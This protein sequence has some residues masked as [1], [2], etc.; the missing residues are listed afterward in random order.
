MN[1]IDHDSGV[2]KRKGSLNHRFMLG[3]WYNTI[4][5]LFDK[6][7]KRNH[8][9]KLLRKLTAF[10]IIAILIVPNVTIGADAKDDNIVEANTADEL[11]EEINKPENDGKTIRYTGE[12][13]RM[14]T[15]DDIINLSS[16]NSVTLDLG[17]KEIYSIYD[18]NGGK[19]VKGAVN[20]DHGTLTITNGSVTVNAAERPG[21]ENQAFAVNA[22]GEESTVIIDGAV[23]SGIDTNIGSTIKLENGA[24]LIVESGTV[25]ADNG[26][27]IGTLGTPGGKIEIKGGEF[28]LYDMNKG[29]REIIEIGEKYDVIV[30]G[31]SF[32]REP[33]HHSEGKA[34]TLALKDGYVYTE[35]NNRWVV[36]EAIV[37]KATDETITVTNAREA[38][39]YIAADTAGNTFESKTNTIDGLSPG[40]TYEIKIKK[41]DEVIAEILGTTKKVIAPEDDKTQKA[42][43]SDRGADSLTVNTI[44]TQEYSI[45]DGATWIDGTGTPHVFSGLE[46]GKEYTILTRIAETNDTMPSRAIE[47]KASTLIASEDVEMPAEP[48]VEERTDQTLTLICAEDEEMSIDSGKNWIAGPKVTFE[49]LEEGTEYTVLVRKFATGEAEASQAVPTKAATMIKVSGKVDGGEL[50]VTVVITDPETGRVLAEVTTDENGSW[51]AYLDQKNYDIKYI[52]N[53]QE[54]SATDK[55]EASEQDSPAADT[56]EEI[57]K[58]SD[59]TGIM[60]YIGMLLV[61]LGI[62]A[63]ALN[64]RKQEL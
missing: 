61:S 51:T 53:S 38:T 27:L 22:S 60:G 62:F 16:G 63:V 54:E 59:A 42:Q 25:S 46:S 35:E 4:N 19:G 48:K 45:D 18:Y 12:N 13:I 50:S 40:T 47:T 34:G 21:D 36:E 41:N 31:G 58:T 33:K 43:I 24:N 23:I 10:A 17:G 49:G 2:A 37:E 29:A 44:A 55:E 14:E 5:N 11:R 15:V 7:K 39:S 32:F 26:R 1:P 30:T 9:K 6:V 64:R 28:N 57:A 56:S 20:V 8:M 3:L 52:D